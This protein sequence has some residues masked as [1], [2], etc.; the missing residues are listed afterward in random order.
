MYGAF[1]SYARPLSRA[2]AAGAGT[3]ALDDGNQMAG[4]APRL[5]PP[6]RADREALW[7]ARESYKRVAESS[8]DGNVLASVFQPLA[9][10]LSQKGE[11]DRALIARFRA[12]GARRRLCYTSRALVQARQSNCAPQ[13]EQ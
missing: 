13:A 12:S 7:G 3:R 1:C 9:I 6:V 8:L 4:S 10:V 2:A 11:P 5:R